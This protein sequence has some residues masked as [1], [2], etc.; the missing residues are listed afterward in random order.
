[1]RWKNLA[2]HG[3]RLGELA[4]AACG[5]AGERDQGFASGGEVQVGRRS[6]R[7]Y[8]IGTA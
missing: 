6:W 8:G 3:G 1:V 7:R 2:S 5:K 4:M